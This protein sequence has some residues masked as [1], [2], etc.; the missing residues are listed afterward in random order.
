M[1][2]AVHSLLTTHS[3]GASEGICSIA[4]MVEQDTSARKVTAPAAIRPAHL[5]HLSW[6]DELHAPT[7]QPMPSRATTRQRLD[8]DRENGYNQ[9]LV[10]TL[11]PRVL[12]HPRSYFSS[13]PKVSGD[14]LD[15]CLL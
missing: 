10:N 8:S 6:Q 7:V 11:W 9:P 13:H 15:L 12:L 3:L 1:S 4:T 14:S 2:S 5:P